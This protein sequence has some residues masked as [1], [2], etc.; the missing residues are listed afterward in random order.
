MKVTLQW[1]SCAAVAAV[2]LIGCTGVIDGPSGGSGEMEQAVSD[3]TPLRRLTR[4]QYER[5]VSYLLALPS[6]TAGSL[7]ADDRAGPFAANSAAAPSDAHVRIFMNLA[8]EAASAAVAPEHLPLI[9]SCDPNV[10]AAACARDFITSF[11]RRAFRRPLTDAQTQALMELHATQE[12]FAVGLRLVISA[13]LQSPQFLY[14]VEP[15]PQAPARLLDG[16]ELAARLAFFL[17]DRTPD[18]AL[19]DAAEAGT[20]ASDAGLLAEA[21]RLLADPQASASMERFALAWLNLEQLEFI[22]RPSDIFPSF[23]PELP[24]AMQRET[25]QFFDY[26]VRQGD[27]LQSTLFAADF[28]FP[29]EPLLPIYGLSQAEDGPT[30][31]GPERA[32]V[33]T[34]ASVLAAT[35]HTDH[36]SPVKRGVFVLDNILCHEMVLPEGLEI[37]P[38]PDPNPLQTTR[39][40]FAEHVA[41]P[42][43]ASCHRI[44]DPLGFSF[45]RFDPLGVYRD[46]EGF[47]PIDDTGVIAI[48][49]PAVDGEVQGAAELGRRFAHSETVA[50][51]MV[52]QWLRFAL[53]RRDT[54]R[55]AEAVA[56]LQSDYLA[57]GMNVRELILAIVQSPMFRAQAKGN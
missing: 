2:F 30:K 39:E 54:A 23:T 28:S 46:T 40:R 48:G 8:E 9:L 4:S 57:S 25:A 26:V 5:S 27:G 13:V 42:A 35:S 11:G 7:P 36:T 18:D 29:S 45:E 33:L 3:R 12:S 52:R 43:C 38:L 44:I 6:F 20:L 34:H 16:Y 31:L 10:D 47:Q 41:A 49:D 37:P 17:W 24:V 51:C 55:D 21:E 14:L 50:S 22:T 19:L 15:A 32:G 56:T 1:S 53:H